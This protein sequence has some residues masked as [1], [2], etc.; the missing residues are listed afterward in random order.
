MRFTP[1]I[2]ATPPAFEGT[3]PRTFLVSSALYL[4]IRVTA[5]KVARESAGAGRIPS[6]GVPT[7]ETVLAGQPAQTH[8]GLRPR[9]S[10]S[11]DASS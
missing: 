10:G 4:T 7:D 2:P 1:A 11:S 8:P 5:S 6:S 3:G 9:C